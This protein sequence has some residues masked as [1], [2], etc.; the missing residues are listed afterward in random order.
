VVLAAD[1]LYERPQAALVA[2]VLARA[3]SP[4][5]FALITDPGRRTAPSL[6]DECSARGLAAVNLVEVPMVENDTPLSVWVYEVRRN[7]T[8]GPA[9]CLR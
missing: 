3:L 5:G 2:N 6:I 9:P 8:A 1:V 7:L 4:G